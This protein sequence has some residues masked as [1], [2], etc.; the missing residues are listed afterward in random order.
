MY[1]LIFAAGLCAA[2]DGDTLRCGNDRVRLWGIDAPE[3]G[4]PGA[5]AA[6]VALDKLI[7]RKQVECIRKGTSHG[8]FVAQCHAVHYPL[9]P[10]TAARTEYDL[11]CEM[12]RGKYAVEWLR[13]SHNYYAKCS[14][15][16]TKP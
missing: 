4:D 1:E 3:R 16:R 5:D 14:Q 7:H 2:I 6:R 12:L 13:Y 10:L 8:R 15:G 9:Y 11:S